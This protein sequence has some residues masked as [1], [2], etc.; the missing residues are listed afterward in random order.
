MTTQAVSGTLYLSNATTAASA[1]T[2][3]TTYLS[4]YSAVI[5]ADE[6]AAAVEAAAQDQRFGY[7]L[8]PWAEFVTGRTAPAPRYSGQPA[9]V[10]VIA[11]PIPPNLAD[12][13]NRV[14]QGL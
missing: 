14:G 5:S 8:M 6:R 3:L 7:W 10:A 13:I 2:D 1:V 9:A 12:R 11:L 4:T